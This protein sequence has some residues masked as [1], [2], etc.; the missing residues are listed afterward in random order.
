MWVGGKWIL[1]SNFEEKKL[2]QI[3]LGMAERSGL[4]FVSLC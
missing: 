3:L 4:C 2:F 1:G